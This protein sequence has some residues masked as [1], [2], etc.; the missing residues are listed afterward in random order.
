MINVNSEPTRRQ[1]IEQAELYRIDLDRL[2]AEV[3]QNKV[4][5]EEYRRDV[6]RL[7]TALTRGGSA[8]VN[9]AVQMPPTNEGTPQFVAL[10][11]AIARAALKEP[12]T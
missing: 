12:R 5:L 7:R 9:L 8:V 6:E 3:E 2:T 1:L 11:Q 4:D 10:G